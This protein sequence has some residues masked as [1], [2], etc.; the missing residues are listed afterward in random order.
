MAIARFT[1]HWALVAERDLQAIVDYVADESPVAAAAVL[2]RIEERAAA[3]AR[4]PARGRVVPELAQQGIRTYREVIV[5]PWRIVYRI[6][7]KTVY[8]LTVVDGRRNI[9]DA[10]LDRL[11]R[12]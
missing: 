9:E 1:V 4:F 8:V 3:L 12:S 7:G 11:T 10:L 6:E 5:P 2:E